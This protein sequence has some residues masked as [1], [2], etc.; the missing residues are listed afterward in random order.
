MGKDAHH[1]VYL[2]CSP[3]GAAAKGLGGDRL[4][5]VIQP[6]HNL[7]TLLGSDGDRRW[8]LQRAV[9]YGGVTLG[10]PFSLFFL[11]AS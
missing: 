11:S 7:M 5:K 9:P 2:I 4:W 1:G 10:D 3:K 8:D 6:N